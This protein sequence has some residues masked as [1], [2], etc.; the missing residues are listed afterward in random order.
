MV[1]SSRL[2]LVVVIAM[3]ASVVGMLGGIVLAVEMGLPSG[4]CIVCLLTALYGIARGVA[5]LR[6]RA[7]AMGGLT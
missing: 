6:Q 4:A 1:L 3:V 5:W 7:S 2:G